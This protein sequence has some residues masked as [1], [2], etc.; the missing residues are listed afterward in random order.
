M[1]KSSFLQMIQPSGFSAQSEKAESQSALCAGSENRFDWHGL[2]FSIEK[3]PLSRRKFLSAPIAVAAAIA[4]RPVF[5]STE[6][7]WRE[8]LFIDQINPKSPVVIRLVAESAVKKE[9]DSKE[10]I[11]PWTTTPSPYES[12]DGKNFN[13]FSWVIDPVAFGPEAIVSVSLRTS[14]QE[15]R[16]PRVLIHVKNVRYGRRNNG[17][18]SL[19]LFRQEISNTLVN[20]VD[21]TTGSLFDD[22][23]WYVSAT[24]NIFTPG[25]QLDFGS[26]EKASQHIRLRSFIDDNDG[27]KV[28]KIPALS[29]VA[30]NVELKLGLDAAF[31]GL[32]KIDPDRAFPK[33][34]F[35][36]A[37]D[38]YFVWRIWTERLEP[39]ARIAE[40]CTAVYQTPF[41][42]V[43][44]ANR[45]HGFFA[46][47]GRSEC[48]ESERFIAFPMPNLNLPVQHEE[49][50]SNSVCEAMPSRAFAGRTIAPAKITLS[51][52][53]SHQ[54]ILEPKPLSLNSECLGEMVTAIQVYDLEKLKNQKMAD[55]RVE[56]VIVGRWQASLVTYGAPIHSAEQLILGPMRSLEGVLKRRV[57]LPLS[58]NPRF[59]KRQ[60]KGSK[61][62]KSSYKVKKTQ[63]LVE[64]TSFAATVTPSDGKESQR[65]REMQSFETPIGWVEVSPLAAP[66]EV[67]SSAKVSDKDGANFRYEEQPFQDYTSSP[68]WMI[69]TGSAF[70]TANDHARTIDWLEANWL[71]RECGLPLEGADF[72]RLTFADADLSMV[73]NPDPKGGQ[74]RNYIWLG[75]DPAGSAEAPPER[76][77]LDLTR[78]KLDVA[79]NRDLVRLGFR[80]ESLFLLQGPKGEFGNSTRLVP[81]GPLCGV[82]AQ[83]SDVLRGVFDPRVSKI[84]REKDTDKDKSDTDAN[85]GSVELAQTSAD[86]ESRLPV[87]QVRDTRPSLIVDFP[88]QHL[89][90]QAFFQRSLGPLPDID[91]RLL[92]GTD[93]EPW[94]FFDS[95][96][97][98][99]V[100]LDLRDQSAV[101]AALAKIECVASRVTLRKH[102][103]N[104]KKSINQ[105]FGTDQRITRFKDQV[106]SFKIFVD[107]FDRKISSNSSKLPADQRVYIGAFAMDPDMAGFA[108]S[109]RDG[110]EKEAG[111]EVLANVFRNVD[112]QRK[113]LVRRKQDGDPAQSAPV[114]EALAKYNPNSPKA[115]NRDDLL[116]LEEFFAS[117]SPTYLLFRNHFRDYVRDKGKGD[118]AV[119]VKRSLFILPEFVF[120]Q[121]KNKFELKKPPVALLIEEDQR[122]LEKDF[123]A[124]VKDFLNNGSGT[125]KLAGS[126]EARLSEPSRL[127]FRINCRDQLKDQRDAVNTRQGRNPV[128][129]HDGFEP[130]NPYGHGAD[131][132]PFTLDAL[133]NWASME[134][135]VT[136]RAEVVFAPGPGGRLDQDSARRMNLHGA[137][138]LDH[139]GFQHSSDPASQTWARR[140]ESIVHSMRQPPKANETEIVL[141]SRLSLST[142]QQAV[143]IAPSG[144]NRLIFVKNR[145]SGEDALL[146]L[147]E[148]G[149]PLTRAN[150]K[151]F[152]ES[153]AVLWTAELLTGGDAPAPGLRA[154]YSPDVAPDALLKIFAPV[155]EGDQPAVPGYG[156]PPR[157]ALA[158]WFLSR[159]E[160]FRTD[161]SPSAFWKIVFDKDQQRFLQK[162]ENRPDYPLI[163][164]VDPEHP[165]DK[166]ACMA[167]SEKGEEG[168]KDYV[169]FA[170]LLPTRLKV[171][172]ERFY[173]RQTSR[174]ELKYRS[175][176]D[177]YDRHEIVMLSSAFGMPVMPSSGRQERTVGVEQAG[178]FKPDS[179]YTLIDV[180]QEQ[181][182]YRPRSLDVSQLTL[183]ALGGTLVHDTSFTPPASAKFLDG[184]NLFDAFSVER[185]QHTTSLGR[186]VYAEV[187]YKG[188]L[189]PLGIPASLV[190]VTERIIAPDQAKSKSNKHRYTA[191]LQQRM[192]IRVAEPT[193]QYGAIG[194]PFRG[195]GFPFRSVTLLSTVTPDIIDPTTVF[196]ENENKEAVEHATGRILFNSEPGLVFWPRTK[197]SAEGDIEFEL[198]FD[199]HQSKGRLLFV[200]NVAANDTQALARLAA[201]YNNTA[202]REGGNKPLGVE[203]PDTSPDA[204]QKK[205][206]RSAVHRRSF[207]LGNAKVRYG[208]ER[209]TGDTSVVTNAITLRV[210]GRA[211]KD[212][213]RGIRELPSGVTTSTVS[214]DNTRYVFDPALQ[215]ANQP[216]FYPALQ[217]ARCLL[218]DNARLSGKLPVMRRVTYDGHFIAQGFPI[219]RE[220]GDS[221][222]NAVPEIFLNLLDG[223]PQNMGDKGDQSGGVFRPEG[224][225]RAVSRDKGPLTHKVEL[226]EFDITGPE[227]PS[228][229]LQLADHSLRNSPV[230]TAAQVPAVAA[231]LGKVPGS[232]TAAKDVSTTAGNNYSIAQGSSSLPSNPKDMLSEVFGDAK[233]LGIIKFKKI[234]PFI[235]EVLN[236]SNVPQLQETVD[237]GVAQL[238][239][240]LND[241]TE[242]LGDYARRSVLIPLSGLVEEALERWLELDLELQSRQKTRISGGPNKALQ[243][244]TLEEVFPEIDDA[245]RAFQ[246]ALDVAV[247]TQNE[248]ELVATLAVVFEVGQRLLDVL[249]RAA[250]E[251]VERF[252]T[253]LEQRIPR[254]RGQIDSIITLLGK[255]VEGL[256]GNEL[257]QLL[258]EQLIELTFPNDRDKVLFRLPVP[259]TSVWSVFSVY[260]EIADE[261]TTGKLLNVVSAKIQEALTLK[262]ED[263]KKLFSA[264]LK[265]AVTGELKTF[266]E[267][268]KVL[269]VLIDDHR[270]KLD[271]A[272]NDLSTLSEYRSISRGIHQLR[273]E[274]AEYQALATFLLSGNRFQ[275]LL[276]ALISNKPMREIRGKL[277]NELDD[278]IELLKRDLIVQLSQASGELEIVFEEA[279]D[280]IDN[281]IAQAEARLLSLMD[282]VLGEIT[283]YLTYVIEAERLF[284]NVK[285]TA[286]E[287]RINDTVHGAEALASHIFQRKILFASGALSDA[288][289]ITSTVADV[290]EAL[291]VGALELLPFRKRLENS[292]VF[293]PAKIGDGKFVEL[294]NFSW[295]KVAKRVYPPFRKISDPSDLGEDLGNRKL[296]LFS[297]QLWLWHEQ[298]ARAYLKWVELKSDELLVDRL[299][300][301]SELRKA[302]LLSVDIDGK[303]IDGFVNK[304]EALAVI[305]HNTITN[306]YC[307]ML[308]DGDATAG[309]NL[310]KS[311]IVMALRTLD[312]KE[313]NNA[314]GIESDLKRLLAARKSGLR[315]TAR[316]A[317]EMTAALFDFLKDDLTQL[318]IVVGGFLKIVETTGIEKEV[319]DA[320]IGVVLNFTGHLQRIMTAS[321]ALLGHMTIAIKLETGEA[322]GLGELLH[323]ENR[324][325]LATLNVYD[326]L[327][328]KFESIRSTAYTIEELGSQL[329]VYGKRK[330]GTGD[331]A[332][333]N[334]KY[335]LNELEKWVEGAKETVSEISALEDKLELCLDLTNLGERALF[336][337]KAFATEEAKN[338]VRVWSKKSF[339][340]LN[341]ADGYKTLADARQNQLKGMDSSL[342]KFF[343]AEFGESKFWKEKIP[344]PGTELGPLQPELNK[345]KLTFLNDRLQADLAYL[346]L[347][348]K[349]DLNDS[350]QIAN[351]FAFLRLFFEEWAEGNGTPIVIANQVVGTVK[352]ILK[353]DVDLDALFNIRERIETYL[354]DLIPA[355]KSFSYGFDFPLPKS[356]EDATLGFFAPGDKCQ[357][358]IS[359]KT[360]INL[361]PT[362]F[363][364]FEPEI[365]A[366]S[367]TTL[368]PFSIK[369]VGEYFDAVTIRFFGARFE[370]DLDKNTE[371]KV[372]YDDFEIGKQLEFIQQLQAW[373]SPGSGSGAF[374][375]PLRGRP[376]IEAGY[377]LALPAIYIGN[378]VFFNITLNASAEIPFTDED[379]LFKA[380]LGRRKS[381]F[382]ISYI[383]Y[384]GSG[385]FSITANA[386]RIVGFEMALDFGAVVPFE[387]GPMR[388]FGRVSA[389][390]YIRK[391]TDAAGRSFTDISATYFAGGSA[392]IWIFNFATSLFVRLTQRDSGSMEGLAA[393]S[394]SFS[395]GL[396]DFDYE[397]R[398]E[399]KEKK[400]FSGNSNQ[401]ASFDNNRDGPN[402]DR[403][404]AETH[405]YRVLVASNDHNGVVDTSRSSVAADQAPLPSTQNEDRYKQDPLN[406]VLQTSISTMAGKWGEYRKYFDPDLKKTNGEGYLW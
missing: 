26:T 383:P 27:R 391:L 167:A 213:T 47:V 309:L 303:T 323:G 169:P 155:R 401:Q 331:I 295:D 92:D 361:L 288:G 130:Q 212:A 79:R 398:F 192:F 150:E 185:W 239:S 21:I 336:G 113:R 352:K 158:P 208:D 87:S 12:L 291:E 327:N 61:A 332:V 101:V 242:A 299:G 283:P 64:E 396:L 298:S 240:G 69:S 302:L 84:L 72:S 48:D 86:A 266:K 110:I 206:I 271:L 324:K 224:V 394:F 355:K 165:N 88:P 346:Q 17:S 296:L 205:P 58:K 311:A 82:F 177:A 104:E 126:A 211:S 326:Q 246:Q 160:T 399:K 405:G 275:H 276:K 221:D 337:L 315:R 363:K 138:K 321:S 77:R 316:S 159:A 114:E 29:G 282:Q 280:R 99:I 145:D 37:F 102:I 300:N 124:V 272:L 381:P 163:N 362:G 273:V 142:S 294:S 154:V 360:T 270:K 133:T 131:T 333:Q 36:I 128:R 380:S 32:V 198:L 153:D 250:S 269:Q 387:V 16:R 108:R 178:Q 8:R 287:K 220:A 46:F 175:S 95:I 404:Y 314:K 80:F 393:F 377:G 140:A 76:A 5:A 42:M 197:L 238:E 319:K 329:M 14:N 370:S 1:E 183:T 403:R 23:A 93:E 136:P 262:K 374:V 225:L 345:D 28:A 229:A 232:T 203:S 219:R 148:F 406:P 170:K 356:V 194:Q 132:L 68:I 264:A 366:E 111:F 52:S 301:E 247:G 55:V 117:S 335:I 278:A 204:A 338:L 44:P 179:D 307:E 147:D 353:G 168:E 285:R 334:A 143:F 386:E 395:M 65:K 144:V 292:C 256:L 139:L 207:L 317:I 379:T 186:D 312:V 376:G 121:N 83:E 97:G 235:F 191:F 171:L 71:L 34:T 10:E 66:Q 13:E 344:R 176:L 226:K 174:T 308:N 199:E 202:V 241:G 134:M 103:Q 392:A 277:Q 254:I 53:N 11:G 161:Q 152:D 371:F 19:R 193:K 347:L 49:V 118:P 252:E 33:E 215:S 373:M 96:D 70:D 368:G 90:E 227:Q 342:K 281:N 297:H 245:L 313:L 43:T 210:E 260:S 189:Y 63:F 51:H 234:I 112:E 25:N 149:R 173:K 248:T 20:P 259:L 325:L 382:M 31:S 181:E 330:L 304:V 236:A 39:M 322:S 182:I 400:G 320:A 367:I 41:E 156:A 54:L 40:D 318:T 267:T 231:L 35:N 265:D 402:G 233:L 214:F 223:E 388:G 120:G 122:L 164:G 351:E 166:L 340:F 397:V 100:E 187:V 141:P 78:A 357:L 249:R 125:E 196:E 244:I 274:L 385:F 184:R 18:L 195:R 201:Y 216:P 22:R 105:V 230:R 137:A 279:K 188:Y 263:G 350:S 109:V 119:L 162:I 209:K 200:D 50:Q 116:A 172:C 91:Y 384:G 358:E 339:S 62:Q 369:M 115:N 390:F 190:K 257:P 56:G 290:I 106:E 378:L 60:N 127:V 94:V 343:I 81:N 348:A 89:M 7:V 328:A 135:A 375:Q 364:K 123:H 389:G 3:L 45:T 38:R 255:G 59:L 222:D 218:E 251:A 341:I 306:L 107:A 305:T 310:R 57:D 349:P 243:A 157:G 365:T 258:V 217:T 75:P 73:F 30:K 74:A 293:T 9:E 289:K 228:V 268:K 359:A 85:G 67:K 151:S 98:E 180:Y 237:Y 4:V 15:M 354:L 261:G 372:Y 2:V 24:S 286:R 253:A 146:V 284:Q 6:R 129:G